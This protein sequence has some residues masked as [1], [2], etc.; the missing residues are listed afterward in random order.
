MVKIS[1]EQSY[2]T[3]QIL[4]FI[5]FVIC[6]CAYT[7]SFV[8]HFKRDNR[9]MKFMYQENDCNDNKLHLACEYSQK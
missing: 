9:K 7:I 1:I 5:A 3:A 6:N 4:H 2:N 8:L